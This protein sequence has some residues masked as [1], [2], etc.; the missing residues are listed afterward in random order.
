M[1]VDY[2]LKSILEEPLLHNFKILQTIFGGGGHA[3]T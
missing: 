3:V 2:K 1:T